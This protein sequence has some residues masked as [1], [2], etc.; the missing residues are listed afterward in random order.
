MPDPLVL[1]E[2][3]KT[4]IS[5]GIDSGNVLLLAAV[6]A[7]GRPL[8]SFRGSAVPFSDTQ[9]SFWARNG[10]GGTIEA[11][12]QHPHVA[13]MYRSASVPMLQFAGR[14]RI[15]DDPAERERAF[16]LS[17]EKERDR[18]PERKGIAVIIDLDTVNGVLGFGKDGRIFC[19]M[20][21]V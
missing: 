12:R 3:I 9:L 16:L 4:L 11:I 13:M 21:G 5:N 1:T 10:N 19:D 20:A 8:L 18:D 17:H 14:A 2:E 7:E 6:D 15:A